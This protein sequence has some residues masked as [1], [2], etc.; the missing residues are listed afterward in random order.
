MSGEL[1]PTAFLAAKKKS[2]CA[3]GLTPFTRS[4]IYNA[5]TKADTLMSE[6]NESGLLTISRFNPVAFANF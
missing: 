3:F 6:S 1:T 4:L 2:G 5:A